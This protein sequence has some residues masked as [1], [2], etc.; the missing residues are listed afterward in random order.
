MKFTT[1][2]KILK[3]IL[4]AT[5]TVTLS[6]CPAFADSFNGLNATTYACEISMSNARVNIK[7]LLESKET[8]PKS[9]LKLYYDTYTKSLREIQEEC[10]ED[11]QEAWGYRIL[12]HWL[13]PCTNSRALTNDTERR[14]STSL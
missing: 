8:T 9:A 5:A 4:S 11:N 3:V 13:K 10:P 1:T 14:R 12:N 7:N 2:P 6:G